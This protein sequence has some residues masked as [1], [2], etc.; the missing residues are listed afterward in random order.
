MFALLLVS[1]IVFTAAAAQIVR[2]SDAWKYRNGDVS[3]AEATNFNDAS[4]TTV[5]LPHP[6]SLVTP[7]GSCPSGY[8]W[9]RKTFTAA[10]YQ[11]K[12]VVIEFQGGMQTV[13][14]YVNGTL[15]TKHLG[16]YDPFAIDITSKLSFTSSNVIAVRLN[17][18]YSTDFPPG[19]SS[20][21][22]RYWGGLYRDVYLHI[23]D[24]LHITHP[25]VANIAGGGGVF[26]TYPSVNNSSATVQVKTHVANQGGSAQS[27]VLT[28]T[29]VDAAGAT[30]VTNSTPAANIATGAS[31]TFTQNFT[32]STPHLWGPSSPYLYKVKSQIYSD[33][34]TLKDTCTT[35]IGIRTISFSKSNGFR[36]NGERMILRGGNRH[37]D[38]P[39][40]GNAAPAR[41]QHADALRLKEYGF[42]FVRMSHYFQSPA[43]VAGCDK[44]GLMSMMSMPG[45]QYKST[46]TS[47][48]NNSIAALRA[49][50]RYH[51]NNPSIIIW[52][53]A[54]NES[55]DPVD[56][57]NKAA[58][59]AAE[60]YPGNQ[61]YTE[62]EPTMS[63]SGNYGSSY[64]YQVIASSSQHNGR[65]CIDGT[66]KPMVF[67]EYGDWDFNSGGDRC[68]RNSE[69]KMTKLARNHYWS[70]N[71]NRAKTALQ[72]DAVWTAID[73]QS[74][75]MIRSGAIDWARLPK[76]SAFFYQSQRDPSVI[77][78]GVNSGPM[79][80]IMN[81]WTS[82]SPTRVRV[83]SNCDQ[84]KLSL[85]GTVVATQ[86]PDA[87]VADSSAHLEHRYYTFNTQFASGTLLAEGLMGGEVKA[88]HSVSTPG[89]ASKVSVFI[90]TVNL[91]VLR[92]DGSDMAF[93]YGSVVDAKGTLLQTT[94]NSVTFT[95]SGPATLVTTTEGTSVTVAAE[96]GVATA[97]L[98]MGTTA[99][100]ITVTA[101][102]SGL[103]NGTATVTSVVPDAVTGVH[104]SPAMRNSL[105][106]C[107]M[108]RAGNVLLVSFPFA[109]QTRESGKFILCNSQGK[110]VGQW[111][112]M[113]GRTKIGITTLPHGIYFGQITSGTERYV[114]QLI[115]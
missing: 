72:G 65:G 110:Q 95:V 90:D 112:V 106:S 99:G 10:A 68:S 41:L 24:P 29:I 105:K 97:L 46:S 54:H 50:I 43:F 86:S 8:C 102:A 2:F 107:V 91:P 13:E 48:V 51:R 70:L 21:D 57:S 42:N 47:F 64:G 69:A 98:R 113:Q 34:S 26:V 30:V 11:G 75:S 20:P 22:F 109:A 94:T 52:E 15:A 66:S 53:T 35:S 32:V 85:N 80:Y 6:M 12:K 45:W 61:M 59:A 62:G 89:A 77:I 28:T 88:S 114:Q 108:R 84:V 73:Y 31:N 104:F 93:V 5:Y 19:R 76:F 49:A 74:G 87:A 92:A 36:I 115:W 100:P 38:Y 96:A 40:V 67:N 14:V 81:W 9:Y 58:A 78:P 39:Y 33:G 17:N 71:A 23:S 16:G 18:N 7:G 3:G 111:D 103:S 63:C 44:V 27:C 83:F 1:G 25:L 79:V 60:E 101:S 56:Y 37:Q 82:S 4:W 55:S